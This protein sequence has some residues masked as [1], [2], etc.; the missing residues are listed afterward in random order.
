MNK[1]M[2]LMVVMVLLN[3]VV[4]GQTDSIHYTDSIIKRNCSMFMYG[5]IMPNFPGGEDSLKSYLEKNL[6][7]PEFAKEVNHQGTVYV[8]FIVDTIGN[9]S[10]VKV[11]KGI[12]AGCDEEAI[13]LVKAM[14]N[15]IPA[16]DIKGKRIRVQSNLAVRFKYDMKWYKGVVPK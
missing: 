3:G 4:M 12:G 7:Y 13:R 1:V 14:P 9:L 11:V 5:V 8:T 6:V 16:T 10:D 15:W 2:R